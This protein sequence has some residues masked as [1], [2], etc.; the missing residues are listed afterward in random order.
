MNRAV[1]K[2]PGTWAAKRS[3]MKVQGL[4]FF[5]LKETL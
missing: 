1:T 3:A 5:K 4:I 2:A